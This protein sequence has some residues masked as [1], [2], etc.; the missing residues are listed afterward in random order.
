MTRDELERVKKMLDQ[1]LDLDRATCVRLVDEALKHWPA[2]KHVDGCAWWRG[3]GCDC[4]EPEAPE[5]D[6]QLEAGHA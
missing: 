3:A 1:G 5:R 2:R 4:P 6:P